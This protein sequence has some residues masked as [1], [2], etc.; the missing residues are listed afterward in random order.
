[1]KINAMKNLQD[2]VDLNNVN[3]NKTQSQIV[4]QVPTTVAQNKIAKS[5]APIIPNDR[6]MP[7]YIILEDD[8]EHFPRKIT[9]SLKSK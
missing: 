3:S 5:N 4:I 6:D 7:S 8:E 9:R 2:L 1:M